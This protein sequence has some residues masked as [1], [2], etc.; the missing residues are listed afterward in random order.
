M[1]LVI[2]AVI[3]VEETKM[4][5][6][7]P[8]PR[9][10]EYDEILPCYIATKNN[11]TRRKYLSC[12]ESHPTVNTKFKKSIYIKCKQMYVFSGKNVE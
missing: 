7:T 1:I 8:D 11:F 10:I 9:E 3:P 6:Y 5:R 2:N 4:K 12:I